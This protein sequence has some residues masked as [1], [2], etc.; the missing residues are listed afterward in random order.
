MLAPVRF[1]TLKH[2]ARSPAHYREALLTPRTP[3]AA[4][5]IGIAAHAALFGAWKEAAVWRG[6]RR[7]GKEWETFRAAHAGLEILSAD[8]ELQGQFI[9][10]AV[11][12]NRD[13]ATLIE[14]AEHHEREIDWQ[15]SGRDCACR[16]DAYGVRE[17]IV[18]ELKTCADASPDRFPWQAT[19]MG[20]LA[21]VAWQYD[22]LRAYGVLID[23]AYIIAA[24]QK[25]PYVVQVYEVTPASIDFGRRQYR[26]WFER[27][28]VCEASGEWP[29]YVQSIVPLEPPNE[30]GDLAL[31]IGDEEVTL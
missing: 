24:E 2:M 29:G 13:A 9:A 19:R 21:Q 6:G 16:I 3:T 18:T 15:F 31:T 17:G 10:A 28:L 20:Y 7:Q 11:R 26:L 23:T 5:R 25:P 30:S 14:A 27:L 1:S 8:E 12:A 4:M 22:G